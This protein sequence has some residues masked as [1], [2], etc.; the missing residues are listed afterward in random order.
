MNLHV[1]SSSRQTKRQ[2]NSSSSGLVVF[3]AQEQSDW[4]V[5]RSF[6]GSS[7]DRG[8]DVANTEQHGWLV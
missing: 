2:T 3:T 5:Q 1:W 8:H 7:G 4:W 6:K